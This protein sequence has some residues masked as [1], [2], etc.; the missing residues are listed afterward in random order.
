MPSALL[1]GGGLAFSKD[2]HMLDWASLIFSLLLF[3]VLLTSAL[4][5]LF[6]DTQLRNYSLERLNISISDALNA[7]VS[8]KLTI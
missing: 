7:Q 8:I 3:R 4:R 5:A 6:K 2:R 1:N